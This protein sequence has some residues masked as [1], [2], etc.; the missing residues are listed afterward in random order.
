MK[1]RFF[2][3]G[4]D[5]L[6]KSYWL[7]AILALASIM[8]MG[9]VSGCRRDDAPKTAPEPDAAF[10]AVTFAH[11]LK[12]LTNVMAFADTPTGRSGRI[13]HEGLYPDPVV[14]NGWTE[15]AGL[16]GP[17]C[18]QRIWS[19]ADPTLQWRFYFD[20]E[21]LPRLELGTRELFGGEIPFMPPLADSVNGGR[22]TY[23]PLPY[24]QSL[25]IA[26]GGADTATLSNTSVQVD[27]RAYDAEDV[28]V[29]SFR[30][31][32]S[33][34]ERAILDNV[35]NAWQ[36]MTGLLRDAG[37]ACGPSQAH[38]LRPGE[39]VVWLDE[40]GPGTLRAFRLRLTFPDELTVLDRARML[41]ALVL[42]F[43]WDDAGYPSVDVPLG[44]FF[45][46][47]VRPSRFASLP[48]GYVDGRYVCRFPMPFQRAARAELRNDGKAPVIL[49]AA[50][51]LDNR[52]MPRRRRNYFH[53]GW[54]T[55]TDDEGDF[56]VLQT[57]LPGT[58]GLPTGAI[59][60]TDGNG[61]RTAASGHLAGTMLHITGMSN[62]AWPIF[63]AIDTV[64]LYDE[65][66]T[67]LRGTGLAAAFNAG[68]WSPGLF[69][70][71]MAGLVETA[72]IRA[73]GYRWFLTDRV[74]FENGIYYRWT[75]AHTPPA[76]RSLAATAYWYQS[77]PQ[78]VN[79]LPSLPERQPPAD[80]LD[81]LTIM[82][83]LFEIE[84]IGHDDEA[85][86]RAVEY[87]ERYPNSIMADFLRIRALAYEERLPGYATVKELYETIPPRA[88][89]TAV[90]R[91]LDR[92]K[93]FHGG[94]DH[95]LFATQINGRFRSY[96]NGERVEQGDNP[97]ALVARPVRLQPGTNVITVKVV[98]NKPDAW[99][100]LYLQTHY[101]NIVSG[102]DW[103]FAR[104]KPSDWPA[105]DCPET[106]WYP[107]A[108]VQRFPL[109]RWWRLTPNIFPYMQS[110]NQL[111]LPWRGPGWTEPPFEETYFRKTFVLP[112]D[113]EAPDKPLPKPVLIPEKLPDR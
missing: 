46:N 14:S 72:P 20:N 32:L 110:G 112:G 13:T 6:G 23:V 108:E 73:Q 44:D 89:G 103:E 11:G 38:Y 101:T 15:V 22:V 42:R 64:T 82:C 99:M 48:M 25:R 27:Y 109:P 71:P 7:T 43:T 92:L 100:S 104:S 105:A 8:G 76:R 3:S 18:I 55:M 91:E 66:H 1:A 5:A 40:Q 62:D 88:Q 60:E 57:G 12:A 93:W 68:G 69:H 4:R 84:R 102:K 75:F 28:T 52:P 45:V 113:I 79:E 34:Y 26:I 39:T 86:D 10:V 59:E 107:V 54:Q 56:D 24:A 21:P 87:Y 106:T 49:H 63:D 77:R 85:R 81:K 80:P 74:P 70:Q 95:G 98:P 47:A 2:G 16:R 83:A 41:R 61:L 50:G 37:D 36:D 111:V 78:P 67:V 94:K 29:E 97:T 9:F 35:R 53:A 58:A 65:T 17:G 90:V 30:G 96:L 51:R 31:E 19:N 33:A